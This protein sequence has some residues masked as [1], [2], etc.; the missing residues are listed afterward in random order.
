[1]PLGR[2][3]VIARGAND[4][5]GELADVARLRPR[6]RAA[7]DELADR[8]TRWRATRAP[9]DAAAADAVLARLRCGK[10]G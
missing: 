6:D 3:E 4:A 1:V 8:L 9:D 5:R 2:I 10:N 7:V